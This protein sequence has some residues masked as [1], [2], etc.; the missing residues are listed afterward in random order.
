MVH[1]EVVGVL[2]CQSENENHFDNE[3]I[4]LLTLFST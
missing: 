1:D 3:K 4:D 2:D